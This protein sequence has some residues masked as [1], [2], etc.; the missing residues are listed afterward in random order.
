MCVGEPSRAI[1]RIGTTAASTSALINI[2]PNLPAD[3]QPAAI[4]ALT[5]REDSA[6]ELLEL[7]RDGKV[8]ATL[9]NANQA[10]KM[11]SLKSKPLADTGH[12]TLGRRSNRTR[13]RASRIDCSHA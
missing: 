5:D 7:V 3:V 4:E 6:T 8:P 13:S 9:I 12:Q 10:Q 2:L 11:L 1:G